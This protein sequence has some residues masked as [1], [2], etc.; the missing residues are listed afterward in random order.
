MKVSAVT[1][2]TSLGEIKPGTYAA[3]WS[4]YIVN[5]PTDDGTFV[6]K[7]NRG[8]RGMVPVEVRIDEEHAVTITRK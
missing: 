2:R 1:K 6:L 3:Y 7:V 4:G 8:V 5:L